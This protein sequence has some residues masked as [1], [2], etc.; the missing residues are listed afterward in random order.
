[1]AETKTKYCMPRVKGSQLSCTLVGALGVLFNLRNTAVLL[2]GTAGCAH[3]GLKFCQQMFMREAEMAPGLRPPVLNF[4]AT[5]LSENELIFGGEERLSAKIEETL[6]AFP[7]L[8]LL[9]IPSCTVEVI[10]DDVKG[11]CERMA[12]QTGRDIVYFNMGGFLKGDHYQGVNSAYFDLIDRF[13]Q[14]PEEI[15]ARKVNVVAERSLTPT[16]DIDFQEVCRLLGLLGLEVNT[17]FVRGLAF[18]DLRRVAR[19]ALNLPAVCNQ[20]IA[21]CER[22]RERFQMPFVREGFPSGF[23][24]TETWLSKI[25][26][27]LALDADIEGLMASERAFFHREIDRSGNSLK[28]LKIVVNTFPV[29]L[30]WLIEF[31]EMTG[32]DLMEVNVLDTGYF[33]QEFMDSAEDIPCPMNNRMRVEDIVANNYKKNADLFLHCSVH[34]SPLPNHLPG[35]LIK[36]IPVI[37]PV[38]PRGL[39]NLFAN[40]SQWMRPKNVEGWRHERLDAIQ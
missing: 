1:M 22:L 8:P 5:A 37:P 36:E 12:E 25:S 2:H 29:H 14:P 33:Q 4:R 7:D 15:D 31:L 17:R 3:Y 34:Y 39:L 10:G 20:S 18:E 38:G 23:R 40:W 27:A 35:L 19:A 11:V 28:G 9:V 16:A 6:E 32:A 26:D 24:D 21:V 30:G 13:L